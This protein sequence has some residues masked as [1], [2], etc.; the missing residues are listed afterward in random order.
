MAKEKMAGSAFEKRKIQKRES[1][2]S[3]ADPLLSGERYANRFLWQIIGI[4]C[5]PRS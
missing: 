1:L 5:H 4:F 3:R 2:V